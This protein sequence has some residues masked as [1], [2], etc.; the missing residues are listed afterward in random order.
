MT[1]VLL[2]AAL[3][4]GACWTGSERPALESTISAKPAAREP[5]TLRVK[6][7]RTGCFGTCPSY[8]IVIDGSGRVEWTGHANVMAMGRRTSRVTRA[9][10]DEL[11]RQLDRA[12][13][14][15]RDEYGELPQKTECQTVGSSTTCSF[16]TSV[17]ICSDTSHA[18]ISA[19]RGIQR[20]KIDNDHCNDRP[21]VDALEDYI[22]RITNAE[23]WIDQ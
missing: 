18:I 12:R 7:E 5:L 8:S 16:S 15:E 6:L 22:D 13:F 10:L 20:H 19:Q 21:E 2:A 14:F 3:M 9:E 11:S 23:S 17:S 1:R 4:C